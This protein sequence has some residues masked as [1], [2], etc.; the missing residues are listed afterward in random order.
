MAEVSYN[1]VEIRNWR[2]VERH[3]LSAE[4]KDIGKRARKLMLEGLRQYGNIDGRCV[5]LYEG[6]VIDGWQFYGCL[7][8]LDIKPTFRE[9]VLPEGMAIEEWVTI[10]QEARRHETQ[11][12]AMDRADKRRKRVA[13]M[14]S[15]GKSTREIAE[16]EGISNSQA[17]R[18]VDATKENSQSGAPGGAPEESDNDASTKSSEETPKPSEKVIGRD[19]KT[20][21]AEKPILCR[22]CSG[23]ERPVLNCPQCAEAARE[24]A[25]ARKK[26]GRKPGS[27]SKPKSGSVVFDDQ[28]I[29]K[30][31][32]RLIRDIDERGN[33]YSK[34]A[35][36]EKLIDAMRAV[37][38]RWIQW[39]A[40]TNK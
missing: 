28:R 12:A 36:Y 31:I 2:M 4:Y 13:E 3:P 14:R 21:D 37:S 16:E 5:D 30:G 32:D 33:A 15:Q 23:M 34:S 19:G 22:R 39:Q 29:Q 35:E 11:E 17:Q 24:A 8:E 6:K 27:G 7:I 26:R 20:Y 10:K 40:K 25:A 38:N 18:D 1:T 9:V